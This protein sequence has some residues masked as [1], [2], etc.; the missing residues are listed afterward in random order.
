[1][2]RAREFPIGAFAACRGKAFVSLFYRTVKE[3]LTDRRGVLVPFTDTHGIA[4]VV[5][6]PAGSEYYL[7]RLIGG[8]GFTDSDGRCAGQELTGRA[9]AF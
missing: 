6:R 9:G 8:G 2:I 7:N 1:V 3:L 5:N 4:E